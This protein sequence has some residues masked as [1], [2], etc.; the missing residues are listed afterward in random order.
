VADTLM[1]DN[2]TITC[3][4]IESFN[5]YKWMHSAMALV[6]HC[7]IHQPTSNAFHQRRYSSMTADLF[8][9]AHKVRGEPAF[10]IAQ[11]MTCPK[12]DATDDHCTACDGVGHWWIIPTSGHRAFPYHYWPWDELAAD[13]RVNSCVF[14]PVPIEAPPIPPDLRDHYTSE[15]EAAIDLVKVLGLIHAPLAPIKRRF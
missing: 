4:Y 1:M 2:M 10:D 7:I 3:G 6:S 9:I 14:D 15:R 5:Y 13:S 12:C 8:L 11:H